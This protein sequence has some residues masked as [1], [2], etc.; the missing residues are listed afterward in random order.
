MFSKGDMTIILHAL[1][2]YDGMG[3]PDRS[4]SGKADDLSSLLDS[5]SP[6]KDNEVPEA[7]PP[8]PNLY[9]GSIVYYSPGHWS[10]WINGKK[11]INRKNVPT[12]EFYIDRISRSEVELIWKPAYIHDILEHSQELAASGVHLSSN[13]RL[14]ESGGKVILHL[15]PNQTFLPRS[16]TIREGLIKPAAMTSPAAP[17]TAAAGQPGAPPSSNVPPISHPPYP[18]QPQ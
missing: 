2:S 17:G 15:R 6:K 16:L 1:E 5:L 8:L 7:P 4:T 12:N 9:L 3:H 10:V 13:I 18:G 14:D 11:L